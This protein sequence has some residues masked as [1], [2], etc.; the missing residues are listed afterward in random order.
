MTIVVSTAVFGLDKPLFLRTTSPVVMVSGRRG[1]AT[2]RRI[3]IH[4]AKLFATL[5]TPR[6]ATASPD[7]K[8]S[9]GREAAG[10]NVITRR[11]FQAP[12]LTPGALFR[13]VGHVILVWGI[14]LGLATFGAP[15]LLGPT[16]PGFATA[17]AG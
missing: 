5:P 14:S 17:A 13:V 1:S 9:L 8:G 4:P 3:D 2:R 16:V 12:S 15:I 11:I 7:V 6:L 10:K